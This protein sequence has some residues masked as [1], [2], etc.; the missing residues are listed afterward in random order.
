MGLSAFFSYIE[1]IPSAGLQK[2]QKNKPR[3]P[4]NTPKF[5]NTTEQNPV[6]EF[7]SAKEILKDTL[8]NLGL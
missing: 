5:I 2:Q 3:K 1:I 8:R 6:T 7:S 4:K